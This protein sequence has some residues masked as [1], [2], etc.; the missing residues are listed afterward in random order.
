MWPSE[1]AFDRID[2]Q[3]AATAY[4][5]PALPLSAPRASPL[6]APPRAL[7]ALPPLLQ[8]AGGGEVLL[9]ENFE[10]AQR[11]AAAGGAA[12]LE[13]WE[14]MWHEYADLRLE[15]LGRAERCAPRLRLTRIRAALVGTR[16]FVEHTEGCGSGLP[17]TEAHEALGV[18]GEFLR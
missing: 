5:P 6:L 4:L 18:V 7:A 11:V 3:C 17:L 8:V 14:A 1:P 12:Q 2:G 13:V 15:P 9:L 10:F 16:S